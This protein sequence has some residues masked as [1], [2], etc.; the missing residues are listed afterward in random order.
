VFAIIA[1]LYPGWVVRE[2]YTGF[3]QFTLNEGMIMKYLEW[4]YHNSCSAIIK[5][6]DG[7]PII[8][9]IGDY[10]HGKRILPNEPNWDIFNYDRFDPN[11]KY[12]SKTGYLLDDPNRPIV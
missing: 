7:T 4:K 6:Q 3:F 11:K 1:S 10:F 8:E 9:H 12:C 5:N 2:D